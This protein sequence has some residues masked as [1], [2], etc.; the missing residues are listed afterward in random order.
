MF[1]TYI[2]E[3]ENKMLFLH[4]E[5]QEQHALNIILEDSAIENGFHVY[6]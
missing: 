6:F 5:W 4:Y 2:Y 1:Y 3:N